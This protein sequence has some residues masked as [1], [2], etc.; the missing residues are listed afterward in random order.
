VIQ[1]FPG[2]EKQ[3]LLIL[4][5]EMAQRPEHRRVLGLLARSVVRV[6]RLGADPGYE[7]VA[8]PAGPQFIQD[9]QAGDP[10]QPGQL[11]ARP[12]VEPSPRHDK[13]LG[14]DI[15]GRR[16]IRQSPA[17]VREHSRVVLAEAGVEPSTAL[18]HC[19]R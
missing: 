18:R 7:P 5:T 14:R 1:A 19:G 17:R 13:R 9:E 10:E 4:L 2:D 3:G 8:S 16:A 12:L 6:S 15:L 11:V